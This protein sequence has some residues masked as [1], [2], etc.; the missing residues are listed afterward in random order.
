MT[1]LTVIAGPTA[2]GKGTVVRWVLAEDPSIKV[3][4]SATTRDPRPG[5]ID[6]EH[7]YFVSDQE[8][9]RMIAA[10]ELLEY[11]VVHQKHRY[12]TPRK[13]V[14]EALAANKQIILEIDVQGARQIKAAMP[15][16]NLVF[17]AP[18]S[19]E[20][21]RRRLVE[22]GTESAEQVEIRLETAKEELAA[23]TEFDHTVINHQVAECGQ[24][25]ID[26]MQA[27]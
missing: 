11:A 24:Q 23:A 19:W 8:F 9:D 17:I 21:L 16:A 26:L 2:V 7:Y 1:R 25:V 10:G 18:P 4:V 3:S 13:P 15:E 14:E 5:E 22:R 27:S 6:G 20:E 12:G